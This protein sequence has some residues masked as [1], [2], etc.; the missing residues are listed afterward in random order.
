MESTPL[1]AVTIPETHGLVHLTDEEFATLTRFVYDKYGIDLHRKR[2]LIEGRLAYE[3][4]VHNVHT[5]S[6][7]MNLL[8]ADQSGEELH[9]FLNRITTNH[10]FFGRENAHFEFLARTALPYLEP[11]RKGDL[12]IWSAG[13]SAG[14]EAYNIAMTMDQYFGARKSQWDTTI[15][16]TDI[17]TKVL[18][19]ARH[20]IYSAE[21]IAGLPAAWRELYFHALADGN[22]QVVEKIRRE[23]V[24]KIFNLMDTFVYRK[25][26][27]IIF[28]RNVMIYFDAETTAAL[29]DKFY[30]ATAEGGYLFIGHSESINRE[31]TQYTYIQPAV[32]Q[33]LTK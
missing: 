10:S 29:I 19:Q 30:E 27:D 4:R 12:R 11:R 20:G 7:Y 17:S 2:L 28:C 26:F 32:Y 21:N 14:Q 8:F 25:P 22:Y 1:E 9:R 16:A 6:E 31:R 3:L 5:F 24:F 23:V 18:D 33:K 15:L 13:C